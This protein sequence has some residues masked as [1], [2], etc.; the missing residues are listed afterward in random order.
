MATAVYRIGPHD[1]FSSADLEADASTLNDQVEALDDQVN[2]NENAPPAFVDQWVRFQG[3]W[4]AFYTQ[5]F[6]GAF[7]FLAALND[8][9]RDQLVSYENQ[10]QSF[11]AQAVGFGANLPNV[12]QP[13]TGSGDSL[14]PQLPK[15]SDITGILISI[16]V[17][18]IVIVIAEKVT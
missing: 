18:V 4:G 1:L 15:A 3:A 9:N 12:V 6:G 14:L 8:A 16:I 11:Y 13:S 10:F 7:A 5:E 2:G 17:G